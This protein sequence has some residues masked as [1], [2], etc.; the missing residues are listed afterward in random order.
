M[1]DR[2]AHIPFV[3]SD[4]DRK[5]VLKHFADSEAVRVP[6]AAR[7]NG[8]LPV[9]AKLWVDASFDGFPDACFDGER[10]TSWAKRMKKVEGALNFAQES[11]IQKPDKGVVK[12]VLEVVLGD[13]LER[14]PDWLSIPQLPQTQG[15]AHNKC[16]KML[17]REATEILDG[18]GFRRVRV[19]PVVFT[20]QK[21]LRGKTERT[22]KLKVLEALVDMSGARTVWVV[23]SSLADQ[24]G[25][26]K[27]ESERFPS[28]IN[29]HDELLLKMRQLERVVSGPHWGLNLLL[30]AREL[31]TNPAIGVGAG[32]QYFRPIVVPHAGV[33]RL[34]LPPLRRWAKADPTTLR[35]WLR[36]AT[37]KAPALESQ[38]FQALHDDFSTLVLDKGRSQIARFYKQ[39]F[40]ELA[41]TPASGRALALYQQLS[42]AYVL[43]RSLAD[44]ES[45]KGRARKAGVVA[46]QLMLNCL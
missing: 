30:W 29:F 13:A 34:A 38:V 26:A 43:G 24:S 4:N 27:F 31:A 22:A 32:F 19:L 35:D 25:T 37:H 11:F 2:A 23:D 41:Q 15:A 33:A 10:V 17:A 16:N 44:I 5:L 9:G 1:V 6:I 18:R 40:D 8:P 7:L 46:R 12:A 45:E 21:Q 28:V 39:W 3:N 14:D 20:H 36:N 42:A